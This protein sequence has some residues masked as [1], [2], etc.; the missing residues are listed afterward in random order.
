MS[1]LV[2]GRALI[3]NRVPKTDPVINNRLFET[4]FEKLSVAAFLVDAPMRKILACNPAAAHLFGYAEQELVGQS[5]ELLHIDTRSYEH[6]NEITAERVARDTSCRTDFRMRRKDG[7]TFASHHRILK[8]TG[9]TSPGYV[10]S[11]IWN[12]EKPDIVPHP[13]AL[14]SAILPGVREAADL[15]A[16]LRVI[17]EIVCRNFSWC[18]GEAWSWNGSDALQYVT[19]WHEPDEEMAAFVSTTQRVDLSVGEGLV[20]RVFESGEFEWI[21]D[22]HKQPDRIF[23]RGFAANR[24][25]F[26]AT[27]GLPLHTDNN[28]AYAIVLTSRSQQDLEPALV[29]TLK[30]MFKIV[31]SELIAVHGQSDGTT[32]AADEN[33]TKTGRTGVFY[34]S[35]LPMFVLEPD[36]LRVLDCNDVAYH[37][38][39]LPAEELLSRTID[40]VLAVPESYLEGFRESQANGQDIWLF[41]VIGADGDTEKLAGSLI[42]RRIIWD[43]L[44]T[45]CAAFLH[46]ESLAALDHDETVKPQEIA[47]SVSRLTPR[48]RE[49][50]AHLMLGKANKEVARE[51][52]S[53]YRTIEVHRSAILKRFDVDSMSAVS[54]RLSRLFF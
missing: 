10:I 17:L 36:N 35:R 38:T 27:I 12:V 16:A 14:A 25:G 33:A 6:F 4:L 23:R 51:L 30:T 26:R 47:Y 15:S 20:G 28:V 2:Q 24:A 44:S 8:V 50:L 13:K 32:S 34:E 18:Y 40:E 46:D 54:N 53:S 29:D 1:L 21:S 41:P 48:Q 31:A 9:D 37:L 7:S 52:D 43:G 22:I 5:T 3:P 49:V 42:I 11:K 45:F 19:W 39:G